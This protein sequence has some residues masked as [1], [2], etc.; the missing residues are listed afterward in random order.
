MASL[1]KYS[2]ITHE[3]FVCCSLTRQYIIYSSVGQSIA[4]ISNPGGTFTLALCASVNTVPQSYISAMDLP[5]VLYIIHNIYLYPG[6]VAPKRHQQRGKSDAKSSGIVHLPKRAVIYIMAHDV[7]WL[8]QAPRCPLIPLK[9]STLTWQ[10]A[11]EPK[12][13]DMATSGVVLC[14][15]GDSLLTIPYGKWNAC[16]FSH[17][18][19]SQSKPGC[20]T[21]PG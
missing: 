17:V 13:L 5:T 3:S 9:T 7:W 2:A 12:K 19:Y 15:T 6:H 21:R 11:I 10:L 18:K 4:S 16:I 8:P 14:E 20:V 1:R